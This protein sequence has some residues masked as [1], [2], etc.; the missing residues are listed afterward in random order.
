MDNPS[1]FPEGDWPTWSE[2]EEPDYASTDQG[3]VPVEGVVPLG[4]NHG[5]FYYLSRA[6]GQVYAL[7]Y[8]KHSR[9]ALRAMASEPHYWQRSQFKTN[10]G[11]IDWDAA[12]DSLMRSCRDIGIFDPD[13][14]RGRG[15]W[16]DEGRVVMHFGDALSVDGERMPLD[17][18]KSRHVY[19]RAVALPYDPTVEAATG[20]EAAR[21]MDLCRA[22][23]W[24]NAEMMGRLLAGW[25]VIAP[26]CGAMP[27][28]PHLW[29]TSEAG[30]G[31]SWVWDNIITPL[32]T[33]IAL[34]AQSK[35]SEAGLRGKLGTDALPVLFDE[36]ETQNE[37]DQT[38]MQQVLDLAR[39]ASSEEGA[40]IIK[41][42]QHGGSRS[43]R[44]RSC[45]AFSSVNV[46]LTQAADESR[47][48]VL[49]LMPDPDRT[50]RAAAFDALRALHADVMTPGF[51]ARLLARTLTLLPTIRHN[52]EMFAQAI[53]RAGAPRR[54]GDTIGVLLAGAWS[55]RSTRAATPQ[56]ADEFVTGHAWVRE[57]VQGSQT[58][59]EW[60]RAL[61]HLIQQRLRVTPSNGRPEDV[62]VAELLDRVAGF[63]DSDSTVGFT[64]AKIALER[65]GIKYDASVQAIL[66][67]NTSDD[68]TRMFAGTPWA[69]A[70]RQTIARAP[71]IKKAGMVRFGARTCRAAQ[72]PCAIV[73]GEA[74]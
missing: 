71:G 32:M 14:L 66:L 52:A 42:T 68:I 56:E 64:D 40:E 13:R 48:V 44:I 18:P 47:T 72:L 34:R 29:L 33:R 46:G 39:Q 4:H 49:T 37:A 60:R 20:T 67:A 70:W 58:V 8:D 59:E 26:V 57:A 41:G 3:F 7:G 27:W 1:D 16:L 53:A 28:R 24:E 19:E 55:L 5:I 9:N 12:I 43:Y 61:D 23:P 65:A 69:H 21:L 6:A 15:A 22:L 74:G 35:T 45:F 17:L 30:G 54:T 31:K 38:R 10:K 2:G 51:P 11:A 63:S 62:P 25:C 36:A 73:M 50:R